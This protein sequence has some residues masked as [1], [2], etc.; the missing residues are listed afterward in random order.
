MSGLPS[1]DA[2]STAREV[3]ASRTGL[4]SD[5]ATRTLEIRD[6]QLVQRG[7]DG[8]CFVAASFPLTGAN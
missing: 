6:V 4:F 2:W 7:D 8:Y 5:D 3:I 1:T